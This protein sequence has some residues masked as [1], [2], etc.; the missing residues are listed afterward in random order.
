MYVIVIQ[1]Y[2]VS[3]PSRVFSGTT[4]TSLSDSTKNICWK[5]CLNCCYVLA[6]ETHASNHS[7][8]AP[9]LQQKI[10][11]SASMIYR[12]RSMGQLLSFQIREIVLKWI[13]TYVSRSSVLGPSSM[14]LECSPPL[15]IYFRMHSLVFLGTCW[16]ELQVVWFWFARCCMSIWYFRW[17]T[18]A[19]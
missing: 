1:T 19:H 18:L 5:V 6:F 10:P 15:Q 13:L 9:V 16:V 2:F 17:M 3:A 8:P 7:T 14:F 4:V 12:Q 11:A